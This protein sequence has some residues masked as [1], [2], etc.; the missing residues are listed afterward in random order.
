[1]ISLGQLSIATWKNASAVNTICIIYSAKLMWLPQEIPIKI[2]LANDKSN[3]QNGN[4]T[5]DEIGVAVE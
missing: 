5:N 2:N 1:M 3:C 4:W